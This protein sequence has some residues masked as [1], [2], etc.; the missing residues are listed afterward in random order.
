[1]STVFSDFFSFFIFFDKTIKVYFLLIIGNFGKILFFLK[2][3]GQV[4]YDK[5][6]LK[7]TEPVALVHGVII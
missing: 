1:V 4:R 7:F 5:I 2:N 6:I 3:G